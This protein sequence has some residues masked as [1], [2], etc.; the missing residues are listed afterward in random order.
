M[1]TE[2]RMKHNQLI[3]RLHQQQVGRQ[4]LKERND[5]LGSSV[6]TWTYLY[7][8]VLEMRWRQ[9]AE[10]HYFDLSSLLNGDV[11]KSFYNSIR[12]HQWVISSTETIVP[13]GGGRA[14]RR[15]LQANVLPTLDYL[16]S[17]MFTRFSLLRKLHTSAGHCKWAIKSGAK[18]LKLQSLLVV[19]CGFVTMSDFHH[20]VVPRTSLSIS[21]SDN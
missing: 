18:S 14:K 5:Q 17:M 16:C 20:V 11:T 13:S 12:S 8:F 19:P 4:K 21:T 9:W 7:M 15:M 3:S 1:N 2:L 6:T 10:T